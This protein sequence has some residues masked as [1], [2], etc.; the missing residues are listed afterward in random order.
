M[1]KIGTTIYSV[2]VRSDRRTNRIRPNKRKLNTDMK[3]AYILFFLLIASHAKAQYDS[4]AFRA[5]DTLK[6]VDRIFTRHDGRFEGIIVQEHPPD[7]ITIMTDRGLE[8]FDYY[9]IKKIEFNIDFNIAKK[10]YK[11]SLYLRRDSDDYERPR[12]YRN[13]F[14]LKPINHYDVRKRLIGSIVMSALGLAVTGAGAAVCGTYVHL[15]NSNSYNSSDYIGG[16]FGGAVVLTAG[17]G[18]SIGSIPLWTSWAK[19]KR[20]YQEFYKPER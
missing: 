3:T 1:K 7:S 9:T 19:R 16:V 2:F 5:I 8:T 4:A 14:V 15:Y 13:D 6:V 20:A 12:L 10:K 11:Q 17:I 18:L